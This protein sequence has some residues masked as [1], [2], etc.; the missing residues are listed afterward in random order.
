MIP[1]HTENSEGFNIND[2]IAKGSA[3]ACNPLRTEPMGDTATGRGGINGSAVA[4]SRIAAGPGNP[5]LNGFL[6]DRSPTGFGTSFGS[7]SNPLVQCRGLVRRYAGSSAVPALNG[8]DLEV[9][10]GEWVAITGPSG[11]GKSTLLNMVAGLDVPDCGEVIIEGEVMSSTNRTRRA[12]LRRTKIGIVLQSLNLLND[13]TA[14]QNVELALRLGGQTKRAARNN[15]HRLLS[16]FELGDL[17]HRFPHQLSGGQQQ[18]VAIARAMANEPA[19]LLADEP[20]GALDRSSATDVLDVLRRAHAQGQTLLVV[21]HDNRVASYADRV[22][23]VE[24]GVVIDDGFTAT[25]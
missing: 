13:L 12:Q 21:T 10:P 2:P 23:V 5:V 3:N 15:A 19:V 22:V 11:S 18:R 25:I 17:T 14:S 9:W 6:T 16:D 7:V 8:A 1:V 4:R 24:D 20:T